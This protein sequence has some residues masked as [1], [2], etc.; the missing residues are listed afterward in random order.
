MRRKR[1]PEEARRE[2]ILLAAFDV[3]GRDG[4]SG[5]T[6]RAVAAE[7]GVSHALVLFHFGRKE[8]LVHGLL[9]WVIG[10]TAVRHISADIARFPHARDRLHALLQQEMSRLSHQPRQTRLFLEF[11]AMGARKEEIGTQISAELE[12]Y[13]SAF[14]AIMEELLRS[15]PAAFA[16]VTADGLAAVAVSWIHGCAVQAMID[17]HHFDTDEYLT[18]VR[19]MIGGLG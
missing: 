15:E 10:G 11:W 9:D 4:I 16:G 17:P 2:Q 14:R 8:R 5:L 19:G 13:R 3:A 1:E 7:A 18:A 12:R 6:V